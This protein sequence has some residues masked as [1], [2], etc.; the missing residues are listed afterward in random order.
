[1]GWWGQRVYG[2]VSMQEIREMIEKDTS[3]TVTSLYFGYAVCVVDD[4]AI[5]K[6]DHWKKV[7]ETGVNPK[8]YLLIALW[9]KSQDQILIK[10]I[11]EECGPC[12]LNVPLKYV[13][14]PC[15]MS[16][17]DEYAIKW[18]NKVRE[19]HQKQKDNTR[20]MKTLIS[21][22]RFFV[23]GKPYKFESLKNS[24]WCLAKNLLN[25]MTYRIKASQ[26]SLIDIS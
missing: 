4:K 25:G 10:Q 7:I 18:R 16:K 5:E 3:M 20:L 13:N 21:G 17:N 24:K 15:E 11:G 12:E 23:Y 14:A 1:M 8:N 6:Y 19:Y 2:K 22:D 9:R 26:L